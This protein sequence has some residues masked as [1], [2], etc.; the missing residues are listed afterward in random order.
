LGV[1]TRP[2]GLH[3]GE[4]RSKKKKTLFATGRAAAGVAVRGGED[5]LARRISMGLAA[6]AQGLREAVQG[7][8]AGR[9]RFGTSTAQRKICIRYFVPRSDS[10]VRDDSPS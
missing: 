2:K 5:L 4:S 3:L 8:T 6:I 9:P 1:R 10:L 7:V